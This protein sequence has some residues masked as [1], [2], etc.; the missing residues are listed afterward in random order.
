[1]DLSNSEDAVLTP[2]ISDNGKGLADHF[3]SVSQNG[4]LGFQLV[5][6]LLKQLQ[7]DIAI[8]TSKEGTTFTISFE[9]TS[10]K[11]SSSGFAN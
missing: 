8:D 11:G 10:K 9:K 5:D 3:T 4:S 6:T 2:T 7:A 1:M